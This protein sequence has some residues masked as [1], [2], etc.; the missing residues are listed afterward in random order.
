MKPMDLL[1]CHIELLTQLVDL[2]SRDHAETYMYSSY[3][4]YGHINKTN[5]PTYKH[6]GHTYNLIGLF[7]NPMDIFANPM[8]LLAKPMELLIDLMDILGPIVIKL[9]IQ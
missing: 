7:T 9:V 6:N 5:G 3:R 8:D 2:L 1:G 4:P